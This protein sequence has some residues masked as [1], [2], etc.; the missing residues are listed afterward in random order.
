MVHGSIP[1]LKKSE[2][3]TLLHT[4]PSLYLHHLFWMNHLNW[5]LDVRG[6]INVRRRYLG[7]WHIQRHCM[8]LNHNVFRHDSSYVTSLGLKI[9]SIFFERNGFLKN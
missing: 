5:V 2:V 3:R 6:T 1:G 9:V 8:N 4:T 7:R